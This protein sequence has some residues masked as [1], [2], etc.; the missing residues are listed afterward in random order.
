VPS[1]LSIASLAVAAGSAFA[2]W[3]MARRF[4]RRYAELHRRIPPPTWM[5]RAQED[6]LLEEPRRRALA[7]LPIL[8]SAAVV[9]VVNA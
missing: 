1:V 8:V 7:L 5:F 6:P 4:S 3:A 9:Y 2:I